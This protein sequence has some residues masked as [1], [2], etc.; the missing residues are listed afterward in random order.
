MLC[1][2]TV[3]LFAVSVVI[4]SALASSSSAGLVKF[5]YNGPG[6]EVIPA[7]SNSFPMTGS[8]FL[9]DSL[10]GASQP[11]QNFS[12][13]VASFGPGST[14]IVATNAV[15][16]DLAG[17]ITDLDILLGGVDESLTLME[18]DWFY[19][20]QGVFDP[21]PTR[22]IEAASAPTISAVPEPSSAIYICLLALPLAI[23]RSLRRSPRGSI[24]I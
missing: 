4:S 21:S 5:E 12:F 15:V 22:R 6:T 7:T 18:N 24:S 8:F 3:R 16:T 2:R 13:E 17:N 19:E 9:D 11:A 14:F 20:T 1:L 10:F 23:R